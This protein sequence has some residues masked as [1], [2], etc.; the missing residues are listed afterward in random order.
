MRVKRANKEA[1]ITDFVA[2]LIIRRERFT[3]YLPITTC[4]VISSLIY[5]VG[6]FMK[7][8]SFMIFCNFFILEPKFRSQNYSEA[9][10]VI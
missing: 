7:R 3:F 1:G 4:L 2:L 9:G 8:E 6:W 10:C 5:F